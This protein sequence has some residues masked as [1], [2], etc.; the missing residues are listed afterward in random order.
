MASSR[1][2]NYQRGRNNEYR[3][4]K[5]LEEVGYQTTRSA[6]SKG[7]WDVIAWSTT[8]IRFIQAKTNGWPNPLEMEAI[9]MAE[10]PP[11]GVKEVWRFNS[12]SSTPMIRRVG[13]GTRDPSP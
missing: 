5:R 10:V 13:N 6:G 4:Q 1:N 7:L 2:K 3:V 8:E 9:S 12:G 11:N